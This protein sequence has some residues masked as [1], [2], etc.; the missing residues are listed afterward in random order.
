VPVRDSGTSCVHITLRKGAYSRQPKADVFLFQI[1]FVMPIELNDLK[2]VG[3]EN[4]QLR[5]ILETVIQE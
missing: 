1:T 3:N 2:N 5:S 4:R